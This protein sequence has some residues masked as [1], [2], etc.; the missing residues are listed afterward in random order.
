MFSRDAA[1]THPFSACNSSG[2]Y[3]GWDCPF[4]LLDL[5]MAINS[6]ST[7]PRRQ[8]IIPLMTSSETDPRLCSQFDDVLIEVFYNSPR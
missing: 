3:N 7:G 5:D 2:R 6:V 8:L 4:D 1:Q